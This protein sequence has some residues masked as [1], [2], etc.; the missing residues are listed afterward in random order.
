M[1]TH[2]SV[3]AWRIPWTEEPGRLQSTGLQTVGYDWATSLSFFLSFTFLS[4]NVLTAQ[5]VSLLLNDS[6]TV[7]VA[8]RF[9]LFQRSFCSNAG[10]STLNWVVVQVSFQGKMKA[11]PSF[12]FNT[13]DLMKFFCLIWRN[14]N[15]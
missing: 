9:H 15:L 3:L 11:K 10:K 2:S 5:F 7:K 13:I 8:K 1:V 14:E 6:C 4:T 12:I